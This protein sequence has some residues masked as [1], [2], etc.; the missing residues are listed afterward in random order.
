VTVFAAAKEAFDKAMADGWGDLD[1][2]C[3]H[4]QVSG[5]SALEDT[6]LEDTDLED[7]ALEDTALEELP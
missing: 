2:A 6:D 4:D 1:I 3:V 5:V 7:T